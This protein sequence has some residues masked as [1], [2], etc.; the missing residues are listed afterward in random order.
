MKSAPNASLH[1]ATE[2][3]HRLT[4]VLHW[5]TLLCIVVA[6]GA[7][8]LCE[9]IGDKFWRQ[10][11]L[12]T[13]RQLGLLVLLGVAIRLGV[14]LRYGMADHMSG[15]PWPMRFAATATHWCLYGL[16]IGLPLLG[17]ATTNAHNLQVQFFGLVDLP[18]LI[19]VDAELAD[20][21]SDNHILGSWMLLGLVALHAAAALYHH[22]IRRDRVLWAMLPGADGAVPVR[23][24]ELVPPGEPAHGDVPQLG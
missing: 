22:F 3:H 11:L 10:I 15:L 14:R 17:W 19:G 20:E 8:L 4:I 21:L 18:T 1:S 23:P 16:L 2:K 6:V 5:G 24:T 7:V 12:E 13:H 9:F